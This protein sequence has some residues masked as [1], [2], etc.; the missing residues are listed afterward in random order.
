M[1]DGLDS[2][3]AQSIFSVARAEGALERV[4]DE[5]FRFARAVD[6]NAELRDRLTD[7]SVT[8]DEKLG[9]VGD[10]LARRAHPQTVGAALWVIQS[11]RARQ[12]PAIADA[13]VRLAAEEHSRAVA[14]V[15]T[16]I[17]LDDVR[18]QQLAAAIA[19]ATGKQV[20]VRTVVDPG[21]VG[22]VVVKVGDTV[23]DGSVARRLEQLKARLTGA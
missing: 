18:R 17:P 4:S 16:A 11:G 10:L 12:L 21:V 20:D 3:Y 19:V 13:V 6:G 5:L 7:P 14:E 8:V 9:I 1:T 23:I 2:S 15:R 22:G